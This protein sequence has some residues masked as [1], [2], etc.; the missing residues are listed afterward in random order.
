MC[1]H[2][3]TVRTCNIKHLSLVYEMQNFINCNETS[4][5]FTAKSKTVTIITHKMHRMPSSISKIP[6]LLILKSYAD[7]CCHIFTNTATDCTAF[8]PD[9]PIQL[10]YQ[11]ERNVCINCKGTLYIHRRQMCLQIGNS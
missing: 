5:L 2:P 4:N 11:N 6:T 10:H 9:T 8:T 3:H 1:H 7:L